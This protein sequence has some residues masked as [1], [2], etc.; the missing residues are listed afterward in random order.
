MEEMGGKGKLTTK[1]YNRSATPSI[2]V[3]Q[4]TSKEK[5][6]QSTSSREWVDSLLVYSK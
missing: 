1:T 6:T 4:K 3:R 2:N 5:K